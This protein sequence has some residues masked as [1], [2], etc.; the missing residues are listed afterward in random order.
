MTALVWD[1]VGDRRYETGVDHGVLYLASGSAVPWNGLISVNEIVSRE[2]KPFYIDGIKFLDHKVLSAYAAKLSAFTYPDEMDGL[3]GT[4]E[5]TPGVFLHDQRC[6]EFFHLSY[7]TMI[8]NDVDGID[9][10]YKIH[11]LYNLMAVLGDTT[12]G[13][14]GETAVA[15]AFEWTIFGTPSQA[16]GIR[17]TSHISLDSRRI[18]PEM[19]T[20]LEELLYG[21]DV[22]DPD[23]PTVAELLALVT[24]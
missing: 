4:Q 1:Q 24:P 10:G 5:F 17:P 20:T 15:Q 21:S 22:E 13:T 9:H 19:L 18:D 12:L 23:L 16:S 2:T 14:I 6:S 7:R 3:V 11:V 8:G